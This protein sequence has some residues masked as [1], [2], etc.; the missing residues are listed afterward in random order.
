M[1]ISRPASAGHRRS[2]AAIVAVAAL[3]GTAACSDD[4]NEGTNG[5]ESAEEPT[6][7]DRLEEAH[8]TLAGAG[9]LRLVL[10]GVDLPDS[11][12]IIKASGSGTMD[13][14]AFDG[15]I[16][17]KVSGVQ[18]DVPTIAV[19][20]TLYV[21]M[22][23]TN[24]YMSTS[25]EDLGV[26]DPARL[27]DVDNGLASLLTQTEDPEFGEPTRSG[28]EVLQPITGT[29]PGDSVVDLLY[30]GDADENFDVEY[31]LVEESWEVRTVEI[32]G[33]FYPPDD[34]TYVVTLDQYG[35]PVSVT[36]P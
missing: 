20:D 7:A 35:E 29:V 21:Q 12:I 3:L 10:E 14:T 8:A 9:S 18:A 2:L 19:D 28:S 32:T 11:A 25:P 6:A 22:P 23:F 36:A 16:T 31:G 1:K 5:E 13:P 17:A 34:A 30:V 27:F 26:P 15:T 24:S 33:P 4:D